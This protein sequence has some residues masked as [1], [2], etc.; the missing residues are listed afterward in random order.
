[1]LL[2]S[3]ALSSR[4]ALLTQ[5]AE[6]GGSSV[7]KLSAPLPERAVGSLRAP[8]LAADGSRAF[9]LADNEVLDVFELESVPLDGSAPPVELSGPLASGGL[10][11]R[12]VVS[13]DAR[14]VVYRAQGHG[15]AA[16]ELYRVQ[17]DGGA[18]ALEVA[19]SR[20]ATSAVAL[21]FE[22]STGDARIVFVADPDGDGR[23]Q[24]SSVAS[25]GALDLVEL[26]GPLAAGP[27]VRGFVT[28][29]D[30]ARVVYRSDELGGPDLEAFVV[31]TAGGVPPLHLSTL[32]G[33]VTDV[34]ISPDSRRAL[35]LAAGALY[36]VPL[37][38]STAPVRID[39]TGS[40][41]FGL[42]IGADSAHAVF[43]DAGQRLYSARL[44]GSVPAVQLSSLA[45]QFR[46]DPRGTRVVFSVFQSPLGFVLRS[47]PIDG[48]APSIAL[49][50]G[51]SPPEFAVTPGGGRVVYKA[52]GT[53]ATL[54]AVPL[55]GSAA[56]VALTP[57]GAARTFTLPPSDGRVFFTRES[58]DPDV[59]GLYV[60]SVDGG[61]AP[62]RLSPL[63]PSL[64]V[65]LVVTGRLPGTRTGGVRQ[66]HM[67][68]R[69]RLVFK[70]I[71]PGASVA[72][73]FALAS[74][75]SAPAVRLSAPFEA[76][77]TMHDV[78]A[79]E[80]VGPW[81]AYDI[82]NHAGDERVFR[83]STL[84]FVAPAE[85]GGG[86]ASGAAIEPVSGRVVFTQPV[87]GRI[88]LFGRPLDLGA[89]A[90]QL[91]QPDPVHGEVSVTVRVLD[92]LGQYAA[93]V[94]E[95]ADATEVLYVTRLDGSLAPVRMGSATA[96]ARIGADVRFDQDGARVVWRERQGSGGFELYVSPV[97]LRDPVRLNGTLPTGGDVEAFALAAEHAVFTADQAGGRI[98]LF[99]VPLAGGVAPL[100]LSFVGAQRVNQFELASGARVVYL[101][102]TTTT[103]ALELYGVPLLGGTSDRLSS[104][105]GTNGS[106]T[107]FRL[108]G[109]GLRAAY[110]ADA[111][112]DERF[113]LFVTPC[114]GASSALKVSGTLLPGS[115]VQPDY[116]F[117]LGGSWLGYRVTG[118]GSNELHAAPADASLAPRRLDASPPTAG[119]VEAFALTPDGQR[120]VY[121]A[122]ALTPGTRELFAVPLRGG[123][124][125]RVSGEMVPGGG[126]VSFL[127]FRPTADSRG[128]VY[129][130][131]QDAST[132]QEL[133][134]AA[135]PAL[136]EPASPSTR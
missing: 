70:A 30:G 126:V 80:L 57:A 8:A 11:D 55:D 5:V 134:L 68:D 19:G 116:A 3:L 81:L 111:Q 43:M 91:S 71:Q 84:P 88:Q 12:Y 95:L 82:G 36:S 103:S 89:P 127:P 100:R 135:L 2:C 14:F 9:Y 20:V 120:V 66:A 124:P 93:Y 54:F 24:L 106:I 29:A 39:A 122:D 45:Q 104:T 59:A 50:E 21:P 131:L 28:S 58:S 117:G 108:S 133:Y 83:A 6:L 16:Y 72:E 87:S 13:R 136:A 62:A 121:R 37:D 94:A 92:P 101:A 40:L 77:E 73:L 86:G 96:N 52:S 22:V 26:S 49:N 44:D 65:G 113:E 46:L 79:F 130:A 25:D 105:L 4:P 33:S 76:T 110:L 128:V 23:Y 118:L 18:P 99:G 69:S 32:G 123:T 132:V 85:A 56:P 42:R 53:S 34:W 115:D 78:E 41:A 31:P 129:C 27:G 114:D 112:V 125:R 47:V 74:D 17:A 7:R 67:G 98:E 75:G 102:N 90:V 109:D 63:V 61:S 10:I 38:G 97:D 1:M 107:L 64:D 60:V 119:R 48:S 15:P 51:G 35:Y